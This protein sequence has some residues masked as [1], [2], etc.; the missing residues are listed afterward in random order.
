[1]NSL[2]P[3]L[4]GGAIFRRTAFLTHAVACRQERLAATKS[5]AFHRSGT[6]C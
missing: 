3:A 5:S 2:G 4:A 6:P 1:M